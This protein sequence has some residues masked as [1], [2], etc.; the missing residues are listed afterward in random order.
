MIIEKNELINLIDEGADIEFSFRGE[1]YTVLAWTPDGIVIGKQNSSS[2]E[3]FQDCKTFLKKCKIEG[4]PIMEALP[5]MDIL[6]H[7]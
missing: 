2:D 7:S 6:Y 4:V 1:M 3:I 5:E